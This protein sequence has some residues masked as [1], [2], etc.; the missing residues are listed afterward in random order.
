MRKIIWIIILV[1]LLL[2][3]SLAEEINDCKIKSE[4]EKKTK[5]EIWDNSIASKLPEDTADNNQEI[6]TIA[7]NN[8]EKV[9]KW[10]NLNWVLNSKSFIN[11]L[12][13]TYFRYLDAIQIKW[14]YLTNYDPD[15]L[16]WREIIN[17]FVEKTNQDNPS[18]DWIDK[19][20]EKYYVY[21]TT[22]KKLYSKYTKFC[23]K[24]PEI[25]RTIHAW[26]DQNIPDS[27]M[28]ECLV[29]AENR[30]AEETLLVNHLI[31]LN[32]YKSLKNKLFEMFNNKFAK[33]WDDLYNEFVISLWN[34]E[35]LVTKFIKVTNANTKN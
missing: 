27:L 5:I 19:L 17:S 15:W 23:K 28:D 16:A 7:L 10:K 18:S 24:L 32:Y 29:L 1:L 20:K 12:I 33:Q 14:S 8:L 11:Q 9:C 3:T 34:F 31:K 35:Y 21:W 6:V 4:I 26:T 2:N 13:N 25:N 30:L 22:D